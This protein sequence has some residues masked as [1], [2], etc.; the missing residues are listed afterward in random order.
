MNCLELHLGN[1]CTPCHRIERFIRKLIRGD[2]RLR[3]DWRQH[4]MELLV[5]VLDNG[6]RHASRYIDAFSV[7]RGGRVSDQLR[8]EGWV[9]PCLGDDFGEVGGGIRYGLSFGIPG[10]KAAFR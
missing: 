1:G 10:A 5:G 7:Q 8:L 9:T 3:G 4:Q 6:H 2:W